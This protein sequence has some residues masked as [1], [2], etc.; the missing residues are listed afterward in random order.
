MGTPAASITSLQNAL[1]PSSRA[2]S[3][4]GPKH[5]IAGGRQRV[6]EAGH[7]RR[8][9]ADHHQVGPL[10]LRRGHEPLDVVGRDVQG[11]DLL[12]DPGV[13]R[14]ADQLGLLGRAQQR[15]HDRVLARARADDK[16][17][18]AVTRSSR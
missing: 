2:A 7:E 16:N 13:A 8:L 11:P 17:P 5:R 14:R 3:R 18:G 12:G 6:G 1:E 10:G 15:V 9:G 4:V